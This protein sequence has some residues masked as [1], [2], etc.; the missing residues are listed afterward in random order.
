MA[1]WFRMLLLVATMGFFVPTLVIAA[2]GDT[3]VMDKACRSTDPEL[4]RLCQLVNRE[5]DESLLPK[6]D[7]YIDLGRGVYVVLVESGPRV[8]LGIYMANINTG[9]Y[10]MLGG[11]GAPELGK[12]IRRDHEK[13]WIQVTQSSMSH[14]ESWVEKVLLERRVNPITKY[15]FL[16]EHKEWTEKGLSEEMESSC[17][18]RERSRNALCV[19]L[20][21]KRYLDQSE[22]ER[23]TSTSGGVDK[24]V[25][26]RIA[27]AHRKAVS[28]PGGGIKRARPP[29]ETM[30]NAGIWRIIDSKPES[31]STQQYV[32]IINDYAFSAYQYGKGRNNLAIE[33][34]DKVIALSPDRAAA[35]L[36]MADALK[37]LA[38]YGDLYVEVPM[39]GQA[40]AELLATA[41]RYR[42]KYQDLKEQAAQETGQ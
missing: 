35:Y 36:N 30:E 27:A 41:A 4:L 37:H 29:H 28:V 3:G 11:Y 22:V 18:G 42:G 32:Q 7:R 38:Q 1:S 26:Q 21:T 20:G 19:G 2:V 17:R 16:I 15:P 12:I 5:A 31:M 39:S 33:I 6:N 40:K 10:G 9:Q 34:L 13:L 25:V 14:G 24:A 8:G 23:L